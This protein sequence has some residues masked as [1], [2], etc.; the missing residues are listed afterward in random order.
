MK[1]IATSLIITD[2]PDNYKNGELGWSDVFEVNTPIVADS[3]PELIY[4]I[5]K[6]YLNSTN[7]DN[8]MKCAVVFNDSVSMKGMVD[9]NGCTM[10]SKAEW[11][12]WKN[13]EINLLAREIR[14]DIA[15][16]M[17]HDELVNAGIEDYD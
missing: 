8:F 7:V 16:K 15:V 1:Y 12:A 3:I 17:S 13:L 5:G 6:T 9:Q 10:I 14:F 2:T 4:K 11:E